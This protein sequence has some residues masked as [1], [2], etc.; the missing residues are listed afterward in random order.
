MKF[1]FEKNRLL[2]ISLFIESDPHIEDKR[3][4]IINVLYSL[5]MQKLLTEEFDHGSD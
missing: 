1:Y 2:N 4:A 3:M 5:M